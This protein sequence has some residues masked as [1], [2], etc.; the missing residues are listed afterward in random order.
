MA[1]IL[2]LE[3][4][5]KVPYV[6]PYTGFD[7]SPDGTQIAF[8]WNATGR[9][10]IY[11]IPLD[12]SAS[13]RQITTGPGAKFAPQWSP[14][15]SRLAYVLD[16]DGGE[17]YDIYAHDFATR[18]QANLT[19]NTPDAIG[20][21]YCWSPD[22][23]WIAFL[24]DRAGH[25]DT[26]VMPSSGGPAR[27]VLSLEY[28]DWEVR[29]SPDG[30]WL[31]VV[32][33]ARGQDYWTFIV[34]THTEAK[35]A[36][37]EKAVRTISEAGSPI[38]A[39]DARWSPDSAR[40][41]FVSDVRGR[42][43]VGL[44]ELAT[45]Q[46]AWVTG[47]EGD[48]EQVAWSPDGRRLAYVGSHGPATELAILE[49][50][51]NQV[52]KHQVG[53]GVHYA[54]R[55]TPDGSSLAVVFD[56]PGRPCD[57][58]L[59]SRDSF[60]QLTQSLPPDL[61]AASFTM[62]AQVRYPSLDGQSVPALLYRPPQ[63]TA[64]AP[65]VVYIHGGPTWLTQVTWDPVVQHMVSR[66]WVVLAPN[67][68]GSTGYGREWQLANRFDLGG[69]DTQDVV[70]GAD[71]LAR[72]GIAD[73]VRIAVTGTSWGGYLTMTSLTQYPNR[74]AAGSAV[75]PFL[76]W[77]TGHANSRKDLQHW[78]LENFGDPE[79]DYD[80]YYERSPYFFLDRIAAPVQMICGAHDVRCPASE[81]TAARDRLAALG[82]SCDLLLYE[83]EGHGFL[84]I[85]NV[86]DSK[87]RR[88][89]FLAQALESK[90]GE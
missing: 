40:L 27:P 4:L 38:C 5:L 60:R 2:N 80:L 53:Q 62:P 64:P 57:L 19:P 61:Q 70:A 42:Y 47:E 7:F 3:T 67:Y 54:P 14:D 87:V 15:G 65:A 73:S 39:K 32:A 33:E 72:E 13:P 34:P 76:N 25:F 12:G 44:Y 41:A 35:P 45:G 22:G 82:K 20:P 51:S 56:D 48:K 75:V 1:Q 74:W 29:W 17:L 79:K 49:L 10:E 58:W 18:Q 26:Y 43:E 11:V 63:A 24:S 59:L 28:P 9:W 50:E 77:F 84:K 52:S 55:F 66:G 90:Q 31:A 78:D 36:I 8:S 68:R 30:Q 37:D 23:D 16:L 21:N 89:N 71:Y 6:E 69:G 85:E 88:V 86:V 83:D 46:T 81:S